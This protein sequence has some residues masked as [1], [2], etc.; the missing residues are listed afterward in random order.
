MITR[1]QWTLQEAQTL[2]NQLWTGVQAH[3]YH[4]ALTGS[5]LMNGH[6]ANDLDLM[7]Y[8]R[9]DLHTDYRKVVDYIASYVGATAKSA[10]KRP[11]E[12]D[13]YKL[14]I[15]LLL[16]DKRRIELFLPNFAFAGRLDSLPTIDSTGT[17]A[18]DT[19]P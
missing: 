6:S 5:V 8:P 10:I 17:S 3:E 18:S 13:Q 7:L 12:Q 9:T 1:P 15:S 14:V 2:V 4:L 16:A 19:K 11:T